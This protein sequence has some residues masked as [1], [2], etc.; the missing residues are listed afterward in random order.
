[1]SDLRSEMWTCTM[2]YSSITTKSW[3]NG[4]TQRGTWT[5]HGRVREKNLVLVEPNKP[6]TVV[7][8]ADAVNWAACLKL[9]L[10]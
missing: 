8:D 9:R 4:H 5:D 7:G 3:R 6:P 10:F 2:R 1:M